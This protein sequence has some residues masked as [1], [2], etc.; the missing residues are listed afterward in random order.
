MYEGTLRIVFATLFLLIDIAS[1]HAGRPLTI[2]DA[3]PVP[4]SHLEIETGFSHGLPHG[5][6]R[7]QNW[8]ILTATYGVFNRLELGLAIQRTNQDA[9][10]AKPTKGFEDLHLTA[11]YKFLDETAAVPA[12]AFS[13]DVK[14]P[15]A[16]R[17]KGLSTGKADE[18]LLLIATKSFTPL[19]LN[20]NLGYTIVGTT[21]GTKLRNQ[22]RGGTAMEWAIYRQ[23]SI[24]G[25]ITGASRAEIGGKNEADFQ[26]GAR[27]ALQPSLVFDVAAGRSLRSSGT[28]VQGTFGLTWTFDVRKS[29]GH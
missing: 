17:F 7:D 5:G 14:L 20:A 23:W 24:V 16:N 18:T 2:D 9:P 11:K 21:A 15:T 22:L 3:A 6:S 10:Q 13:L 1:V 12:L 19:T 25:E 28:T 4:A 26:L 8:P 27:Y 29:L